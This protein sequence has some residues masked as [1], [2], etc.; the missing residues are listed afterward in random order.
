MSKV[1]AE[2]S[3][4]EGKE[5][6]E[7]EPKVSA[8]MQEALDMGYNPEWDGPEDE[9]KTPGEFVRTAKLYS[10]ITKANQRTRNVEQKYKTLQTSVQKIAKMQSEFLKQQNDKQIQALKAAKNRAMRDQDFDAVEQYETQLEAVNKLNV[11]EVAVKEE[12]DAPT[13]DDYKTYYED[14][15]IH[16]NTWYKNDLGL[17][18]EANEAIKTYMSSNPTAQPDELFNHISTVMKSRVRQK[19]QEVPKKKGGQV[20]SATRSTNLKRSTTRTLNDFPEEARDMARNMIDM[21]ISHGIKPEEATRQ[22]LA[23]LGAK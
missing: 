1:E 19:T 7:Q 11:E 5:P 15:W 3:K 4:D 6:D 12:S 9:Y 17:Q 14:V 16:E 23:R 22:V 18:T 13:K 20:E 8:L 2:V 21:K 10:D